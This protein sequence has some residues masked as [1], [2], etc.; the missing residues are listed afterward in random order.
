MSVRLI[1][2]ASAQVLHAVLTGGARGDTGGDVR[3]A[4][5]PACELDVRMVRGAEHRPVGWWR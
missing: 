5:C 3:A 2:L 1:A 4:A